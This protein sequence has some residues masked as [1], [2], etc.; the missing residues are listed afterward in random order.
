MGIKKP[1]KA[2]VK[3][4]ITTQQVD[5]LESELVDKPYGVKVSSISTKV[6]EQTARTTIS[7]PKSLLEK[8]EDI[9]L[10]NKREGKDPKSVSGIIREALEFYTKKNKH[11]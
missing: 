1:S 4:P 11:T 9:A 7:L 3:P 10:K 5:A 6:N 8:T 2:S